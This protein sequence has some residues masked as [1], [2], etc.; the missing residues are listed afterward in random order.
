METALKRHF[1]NRSDRSSLRLRHLLLAGGSIAEWVD[2]TDEEWDARL[3]DVA[4][5]ALRAGAAFVTVHPHEIDFAA[6]EVS[7]ADSLPRRDMAIGGV[8][9]VVNPVADGRQR[10]RQVV[11]SWPP[12]RRLNEKNMSKA[13]FGRAGEP[14]LVIVLGPANHLPMSLVWELAYGELVFIESDWKK[15]DLGQLEAA[16]DE[17]ALRQR[18]FGGIE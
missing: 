1:L 10:I 6:V 13:L 15:L 14:D 7:S 12:R 16:I 8:K 18:R 2:F 11:E 5:A 17:F 4:S 3:G 9:V